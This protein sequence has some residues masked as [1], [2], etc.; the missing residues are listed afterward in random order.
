MLDRILEFSDLL[1][2]N[3][4]RVSVPENMDAASALELVGVGDRA[5]F[6]SALRSALVKQA[7]DAKAFDELFDLFFLGLGGKA[8][9][10]DEEL[11]RQLGMTDRK[12]TRLNSSH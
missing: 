2:R 12:S 7:S 10:M 6:R 1:R 5:V 4:L 8:R 3:G 9:E 11:M